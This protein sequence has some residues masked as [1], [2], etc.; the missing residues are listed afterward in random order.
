MKGIL[1]MNK[2]TELFI[3]TIDKLAM[4]QGSY[5]RM[6]RDIHNAIN[7]DPSIIAKLNEELPKFNDMLDVIMYL[8]Q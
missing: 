5:S 7:N 2:N 4:C 1:I 3:K 6:S 8:E